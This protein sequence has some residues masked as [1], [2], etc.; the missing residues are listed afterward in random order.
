MNQVSAYRLLM[1]ATAMLAVGAT[2]AFAQDSTSTPRTTSSR[3]IPISKEA[4]GEVARVDTVTVYHTDTLSLPGRVDTVTVNNTVTRVDTVQAAPIM[5]PVRLPYGMY[6]GVG[7]GMNLPE[8]SLYVPNSPG[9]AYQA[10]LGWQGNVLGL[11]LDGGYSQLGEDSQFAP[12]QADPDIVNVNADLKLALPMF[13]HLFGL[14]PRFSL[15][16]LGG[17]SYVTYKNLPMVVNAGFTTPTGGTTLSNGV[18]VGDTPWQ[19]KFGWNAGGGMSIAWNRTELFVESRLIQFNADN[20]PSARQIPI[21]L[22]IN[23]Y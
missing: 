6:F 8:G 9:S 16:G 22:G 18:L 12:F 17:G 5:R 2:V 19:H 3:R 4:S 20:A 21:M 23:W 13:H 15:Y 7:A 1:G 14:A 11:R 10:Q